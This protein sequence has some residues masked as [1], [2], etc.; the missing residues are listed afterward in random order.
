M[1]RTLLVPALAAACAL[2]AAGGAAIPVVGKTV[3]LGPRTRTTGCATGLRPDRRCSPGAYSNGLT[4]RVLCSKRFRTSSIRH[5]SQAEKSRVER[6]YGLAARHYGRSLEIDH[7]VPLEL[8]G[9]NA[10][11]NLFPE[12]APGY[13]AKD[14]LEN[15]LHDLVC[16]RRMRLRPA[17]RAIASN[18]IALYRRVFGAAP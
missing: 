4:A 6:E 7:I 14:R 16:A 5:V 8:G 17:Q 13:H 10:A 18:W 15:R 1:R 9:A 2:P 3:L 11:A 12:R